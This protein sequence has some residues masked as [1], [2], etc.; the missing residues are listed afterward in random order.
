MTTIGANEAKTHFSGLL[1]RVEG[2]ETVTVTRHDV[3]IARLV[4]VSKEVVDKHSSIEEWRRYRRQRNITLGV[5]LT[6]R[7][8]IDEGRM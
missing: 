1:D 8:A 6:I 4:P 7:E 2:G 3:A 5:D